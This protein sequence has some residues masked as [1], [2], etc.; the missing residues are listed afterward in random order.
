MDEVPA[1]VQDAVTVFVHQM[2]S[3]KL[4]DRVEIGVYCAKMIRSVVGSASKGDTPEMLVSRIQGLKKALLSGGNRAVCIE[5]ICERGCE[6]V[7]TSSGSDRKGK[8]SELASSVED[9][10]GLLIDQSVSI[11]NTLRTQV[12][13]L[14]EEKGGAAEEALCEAI[15]GVE[16]IRVVIVDTADACSLND[17]G[18]RALRMAERLA[19]YDGLKTQVVSLANVE[20]ALRAGA[21]Q[22]VFLNAVAVDGAAGALCVNGARYV[23]SAARSTAT[24]V[25]LLAQW[26]DSARAGSPTVAALRTLQS[27]PGAILDY[28][29][30]RSCTPAL[31]AHVPTYDYVELS[32]VDGIVSDAGT[33][34]ATA[35]HVTAKFGLDVAAVGG[36]ERGEK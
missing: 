35:T 8:L 29:V 30:A 25:W 13:I 15:D 36:L 4:V 24:R 9:A 3:G 14:G 18:E 16:E 12:M 34:A 27:H 31:R 1:E 19:K 11:V 33:F 7:R 10:R 22:G 23:A 17:C 6:I 20:R 32:R 26:P 21:A 2:D 5:R 28:G